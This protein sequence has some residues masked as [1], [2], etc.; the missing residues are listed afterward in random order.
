MAFEISCECGEA[1]MVSS[2]LGG[3]IQSCPQ[4][5]R[6]FK[7]PLPES[8]SAKSSMME[9]ICPQCLFLLQGE[10][11]CPHCGI[12]IK[13]WRKVRGKLKK[14]LPGI[15]LR[16]SSGGIPPEGQNLAQK[17]MTSM[18]AQME[19][20]REQLRDKQDIQKSLEEAR[21]K[22]L[23]MLPP[24]PYVPGLQFHA[25]YKPSHHIGGDF[26]DFIRI[27][28]TEIGLAI[29]DVSGHGLE[30]GLVMGMAKKTLGI[31][32]KR[33]SSPKEV[34]VWTNEDLYEDLDRKT[35][36]TIF[37]GVLN[38]EKK[39][40]Q[41]VKA[42]HNPL[43]LYNARRKPTIQ[44]HNTEGMGVGMAKGQLFGAVLQEKS[45]TLQRGDL[46]IQFTDG[47]TEAMDKEGNLFGLERLM[48]KI[49]EYGEFDPEYLI[50]LLESDVTAY[51]GKQE[52]QDDITVIACK[53]E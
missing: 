50:Y 41:Y 49:Q 8:R 45:L 9:S 48:E 35:F 53:V 7:V 23:T 34:L 42:G 25:L 52:Q 19:E 33:S 22:Q 38:T 11:I 13:A 36:V 21:K 44:I 20:L 31:Y 32:G 51:S 12:D 29:G 5:F 15:H 47:L 46:L 43:I 28:E 24:L 37:Y 26:Y 4:C 39:T 18:K 27:S 2:R 14:A 6:K 3:Q 30:A 40:L 17:V 16:P 1:L 10:K